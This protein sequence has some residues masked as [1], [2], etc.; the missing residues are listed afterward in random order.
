MKKTVRPFTVEY[1]SKR[2]RSRTVRG[3]VALRLTVRE[4]EQMTAG[5]DMRGELSAWRSLFKQEARS[6]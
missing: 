2:G 6:P 5:K 3:G 4:A 1:R